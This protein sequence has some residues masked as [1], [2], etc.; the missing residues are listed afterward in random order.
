MI[1]LVRTIL[2]ALGVDTGSLFNRV[3]AASIDAAVKAQGLAA[4]RADLRRVVP[5]I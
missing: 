1:G 3:A 2:R 4:L 5:D